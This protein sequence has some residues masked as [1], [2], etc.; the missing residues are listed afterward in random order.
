L[1]NTENTRTKDNL[2]KA[3]NAKYSKTKLAWFSCFLRHSARKQT[4]MWA[5]STTLLRPQSTG[6]QQA[7]FDI[8]S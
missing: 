2:E 4:T 3:N 7:R 1:K 6:E 8:I 5:Y